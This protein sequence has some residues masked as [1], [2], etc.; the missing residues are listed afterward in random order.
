MAD[1]PYIGRHRCWY[2]S[3]ADCLIFAKWFLRNV[4]N[5]TAVA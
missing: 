4:Q 2:D 5:R 3:A 1:G